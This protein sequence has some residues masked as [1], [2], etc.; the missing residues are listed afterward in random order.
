MEEEI[1]DALGTD[2]WQQQLHSFSNSVSYAQP[3]S[4]TS[5]FNAAQL[6]SGAGKRK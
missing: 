2:K 1:A 5:T 3:V 6:M 4:G